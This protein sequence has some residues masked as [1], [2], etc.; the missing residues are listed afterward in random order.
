MRSQYIDREARQLTPEELERIAP[1]RNDRLAYGYR[2]IRNSNRHYTNNI[3]VRFVFSGTFR[4]K[5][6]QTPRFPSPEEAVLEYVDN[7]QKY[8][9][10]EMLNTPPPVY[11]PPHI[12]AS[13]MAHML[14]SNTQFGLRGVLRADGLHPFYG[15]YVRNGV[16]HL[17]VGRDT[18]VEAAWDVRDHYP[19]KAVGT[20]YPER[21]TYPPVVLSEIERYRTVRNKYGYMYVHHN[22]ARD[23]YRCAWKVDGISKNTGNWPSIEEAVWEFHC[24]TKD[25]VIDSQT[26]GRSQMAL[27]HAFA[28]EYAKLS[29]VVPWQKVK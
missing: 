25:I 6:W 3:V 27:A 5:R 29:Q 11:Y 7:P 13:E 19:K 4:G 23:C 8:H 26:S 21:V 12:I 17:G 24:R 16:Q 22:T 15:R 28:A 20:V 2:Y 10:I 1:F 9:P 14:D 18:P